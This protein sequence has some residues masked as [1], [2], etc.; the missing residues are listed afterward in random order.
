M[1]HVVNLFQTNYNYEAAIPQPLPPYTDVDIRV[2]GFSNDSGAH[3]ANVTE[4]LLTELNSD[5]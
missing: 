2:L 3:I 4:I 5:Y 1:Y